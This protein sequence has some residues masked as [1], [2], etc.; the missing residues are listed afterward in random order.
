MRYLGILLLFLCAIGTHTNCMA[1]DRDGKVVPYD[2]IGREV[3]VQGRLLTPIGTPVS[4]LGTWK[5]RD[6]SRIKSLVDFGKPH[7]AQNTIGPKPSRKD[8]D[9]IVESGKYQGLVFSV[10]KLN[11]KILDC[12]IEY[13]R[14]HVKWAGI[15]KCPPVEE[16]AEWNVKV[17]ETIEFDGLPDAVLD[18]LPPVSIANDYG[19]VSVINAYKQE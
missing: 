6:D 3:V 5:L 13:P 19:C 14:H 8:R 7:Q 2:A 9:K 4:V 11:G 12:P 15:E 10:T 1:E 17:F 16:G 18:D